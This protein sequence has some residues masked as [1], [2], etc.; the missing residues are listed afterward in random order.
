MNQQR[1]PDDD[2]D[3]DDWIGCAEDPYEDIADG[4]YDF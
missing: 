1:D 4:D 3:D 2:D